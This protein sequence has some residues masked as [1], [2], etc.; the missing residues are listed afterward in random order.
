MTTEIATEAEIVTSR[1]IGIESGATTSAETT[2]TVVDPERGHHR[3]ES[4]MDSG[5][6]VHTRGR[7]NDQPGSHKATES[8]RE[9]VPT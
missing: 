4:T 6:N 9:S 2:E 8:G 1:E 7:T 5:Q 3:P